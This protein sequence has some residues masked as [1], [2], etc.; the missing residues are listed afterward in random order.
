VARR[1]YRSDAL[2]SA[3]KTRPDEPPSTPE[4]YPLGSEPTPSSAPAPNTQAE[5]KHE[6]SGLAAQL[7]AMRAGPDPLDQYISFH[8]PGALP[9]ERQWLRANQHHLNNPALIHSAATIAMQRGCPRGSAEFLQFCNALLDQHHAAM[10]AQA[11]PAPAPS[12]PE[13]PPPVHEPMPAPPMAHADIETEH[14]DSG[15]P[16]EDHAMASFISAPPSRGSNYAIE[17]EPS[18][19]SV[20]LS[21][22]QRDMAHRS[23]PHLS[24]DQAEKS[25]AA[26]LIKMQKM[27]KS[28]L[29]K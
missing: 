26:N 27:Q 24:A 25:Y 19:G 6:P 2:S 11:A 17:H 7:A 28:G 23:M 15:Q 10:Q 29:I 21:A 14:S 13:A 16:D 1:R 22:E 8:F 3:A 18:A 20:R 12:M 4:S 9:V 5:A